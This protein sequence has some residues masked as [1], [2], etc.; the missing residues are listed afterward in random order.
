[1]KDDVSG[2][3]G[4]AVFEQTSVDDMI[5]S[6]T[7]SVLMYRLID[8]EFNISVTNPDLA[9]YTGESD[10]MFDENGKRKERSVYGR[11]WVAN[12]AQP[13]T[14][15]IVLEGEWELSDNCPELSVVV[16]E[17]NTYITASTFECITVSVKLTR[18]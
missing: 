2:I 9:L 8:N 15:D 16:S 4:C 11:S 17:G 6:A 7:P 13:R 18:R 3:T 1:M 5:L 14:V 10:E 12:P